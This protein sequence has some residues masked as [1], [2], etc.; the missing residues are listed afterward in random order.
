MTQ[1]KFD[2]AEVLVF[3][4]TEIFN[5]LKPQVVN[6]LETKPWFVRNDLLSSFES[7]FEDFIEYKLRWAVVEE[8]NKSYEEISTIVDKAFIADLFGEKV[9]TSQHWEEGNL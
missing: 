9:L 1:L 7:A 6:V 5:D 8:S 2:V 3:N 4:K